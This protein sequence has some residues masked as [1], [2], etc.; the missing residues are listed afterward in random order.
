MTDAL[1]DISPEP[2]PL[3]GLTYATRWVG[4]V[5]LLAL[6]RYDTE[7]GNDLRRIFVLRADGSGWKEIHTRAVYPQGSP[8]SDPV[9]AASWIETIGPD[10]DG[11]KSRTDRD[12]APS[13][14]RMV[15][16]NTQG[17]ADACPGPSSTV[18]QILEN[19]DP[20]LMRVR[21]GLG[22]LEVGN[23]VQLLR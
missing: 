7:R 23:V 1:T 6:I 22:C 8:V 12:A 10:G 4:D 13:G 5:L 20:L 2:M 3:A 9:L 18:W 21:T 11:A 19:R 17:G 15:L 14:Q 16:P